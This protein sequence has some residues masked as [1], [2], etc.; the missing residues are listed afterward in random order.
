[1]TQFMGAAGGTPHQRGLFGMPEDANPDNQ[2]HISGGTVIVDGSSE[3]MNGAIDYGSGEFNISGGF[4]VAVGSA[5]MAQAPSA[6]SSQCSLLVNFDQ[7]QTAS[8]LVHVEDEQGN[9]IVTIVPTKPF[10]SLVVSSPAFKVGAKY[11]VYLGGSCSGVVNDGVCTGDYTPGTRFAQVTLTAITT[12]IG[13]VA[14]MGPGGPRRGT[15][16]FIPGRR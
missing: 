16:P 11:S 12:F 8:T 3:N 14:Q 13:Q 9:P 6:S 10:Q 15:N 2:L 1:M 7:P 4:L 5:G